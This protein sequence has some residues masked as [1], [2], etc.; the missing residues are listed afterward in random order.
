MIR[1]IFIGCLLAIALTGCG[2]TNNEPPRL[3]IKPDYYDGVNPLAFSPDR[4]QVITAGSDNIIRL[5]DIT[6]GT[7]VRQYSGHTEPVTTLAFSADGDRFVSGGWDKTLRLWNVAQPEAL[8]VMTGHN[9]ALQSV[10]LSPD[11]RTITS[12]SVDGEIRLWSASDGQLLMTAMTLND[13]G[14]IGYTETHDFHGSTGS[15]QFVRWRVD[16]KKVFR[17]DLNRQYHNA[18]EIINRLHPPAARE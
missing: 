5:W 7:L 18:E 14:W 3:Y 10:V 13:G 15:D 4:N 1:N 16:G 17:E 8:R 11:N 12:K 9:Y 6:S 2:S